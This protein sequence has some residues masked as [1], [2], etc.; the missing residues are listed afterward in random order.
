MTLKEEK[1]IKTSESIDETV[2]PKRR[3]H[4]SSTVKARYEK[5]TYKS[6]NIKFRI[7]ED[8]DLIDIIEQGKKSGS[9]PA[10]TI[11]KILRDS[12]Q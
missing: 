3:T 7:K 8:A 1:D 6:Y 10:E 11:K 5:K 2:K 12:L 9:S 4:T